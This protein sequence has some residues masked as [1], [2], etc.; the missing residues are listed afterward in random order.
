MNHTVTDLMINDEHNSERVIREHY[1][2]QICAYAG[3]HDYGCTVYDKRRTQREVTRWLL[4]LHGFILE[5]QGKAE[6]SAYWD[7]MNRKL[8]L[9]QSVLRKELALIDISI[10]CANYNEREGK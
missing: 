3:E 10:S 9:S 5:T 4:Q 1:Q 6:V 8:K 7:M 2:A